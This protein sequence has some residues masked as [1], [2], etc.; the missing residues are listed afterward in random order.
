MSD[1]QISPVTARLMKA[2]ERLSSPDRWIKCKLRDPH[3]NGG[4][5][6]C[7]RGA[8]IESNDVHVSGAFENDPVF[9]EADKLLSAATLEL[10]PKSESCFGEVHV[11]FNNGPDTSFD[12]VKAILDR[13]ITKSMEEVPALN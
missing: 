11:H 1:R 7:I 10:F 3:P 8:I 9:K 2:N 5:A 12:S 4:W 6:Y 13:A